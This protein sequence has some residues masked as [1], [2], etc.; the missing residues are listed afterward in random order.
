MPFAFTIVYKSTLVPSGRVPNAALLIVFL[1]ISCGVGGGGG[2]AGGSD[3]PQPAT[4]ASR[5]DTTSR[6]VSQPAS[7]R[8][9]VSPKRSLFI[10]DPPMKRLDIEPILARGHGRTGR[11]R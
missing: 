10:D 6:L 8:T 4:P 7:R 2:G 3:L 5:A 1:D 11:P 9:R